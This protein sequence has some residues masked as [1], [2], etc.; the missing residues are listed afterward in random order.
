MQDKGF[1]NG[2]KMHSNG[3]RARYLAD[4]KGSKD[5]LINGNS[6]VN[7]NGNN[8]KQQKPSKKGIMSSPKGR[9]GAW[10]VIGIVLLLIFGA[11]AVSTNAFKTTDW[12][13]IK[14]YNDYDLS[15]ISDPSVDIGKFAFH[16]NRGVLEFYL[17]FKG[18]FS[19]AEVYKNLAYIFIDNDTNPLTGYN[20]GYLGADYAVKISGEHGKITASFMQFNAL[21]RDVWNWTVLGT[22]SIV[23]N[24]NAITGSTNHKI[25]AD[26]RIFVVAQHG[27]VQDITPVVGIERPAVLIVEKPLRNST[28]RIDYWPM[29]GS[30]NIDSIEISVPMGV[31]IPGLANNQFSPG[32]ITLPRSQYL[33]IDTA[34]VPSGS[35]KV[36]I[37]KVNTNVPYTIWG[38]AYTEY[39]GVPDGITID[40]CFADW[41]TLVDHFNMDSPTNDV[42]NPNI[43]I[44]RHAS[45]NTGG[46][47][48]YVDVKGTMLAGNIAPELEEVSTGNWTN[49]TPVPKQPGSPYDYAEITFTTAHH[50]THTIL[51]TGYMGKVVSVRLDGKKTDI[52]KAAAGINK[53]GDIGALEVGYFENYTITSYHIKMTDWSG[54]S[55][56]AYGPSES[57]NSRNG[58]DEI[59]PEL[60]PTAIVAVIF[61][62]AVPV[63]LRR[64]RE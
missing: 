23:R 10:T 30:V 33:E 42:D 55:D 32:T 60:S 61:V 1:V 45:Y 38:D 7:G 43:N 41:N 26:A 5:G 25:N 54:A 12:N 39:V 31:Q 46:V 28:L 11:F 62:M 18:D 63:V 40:G 57:G 47:F 51:I 3:A 22:V 17:S 64:R 44:V 13:L 50:G 48:F 29:Y 34:N 4:G 2:V 56:E 21:H 37:S 49:V 53:N 19:Q 59:L 8:G 14:K 9:L 24:G 36:E 20:A 16:L 58:G 15:E 52:V 27:Y 6:L 35:V